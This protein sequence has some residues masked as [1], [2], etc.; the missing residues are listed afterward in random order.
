MPEEQNSIIFGVKVG[1]EVVCRLFSPLSYRMYVFYKKQAY[2]KHG[3]HL[4]QKWTSCNNNGSC[5]QV[6]L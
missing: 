5:Y 3:A 6:K 1:S 4:R 2:K